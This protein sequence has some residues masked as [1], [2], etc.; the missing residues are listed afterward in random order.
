[1]TGLSAGPNYG[2]ERVDEPEGPEGARA[3]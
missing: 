2:E 1:L 3:T